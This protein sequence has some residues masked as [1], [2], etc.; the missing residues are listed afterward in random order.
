VI[1]ELAVVFSVIKNY[2]NPQFHYS[3]NLLIKEI[4]SW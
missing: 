2:A 1:R 3:Q 4:V